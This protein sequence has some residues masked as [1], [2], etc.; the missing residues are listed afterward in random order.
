MVRRAPRVGHSTQRE[1][2]LHNLMLDQEAQ[3]NFIVLQLN[4][5]L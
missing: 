4:L 5:P 2:F 1:H 3:I